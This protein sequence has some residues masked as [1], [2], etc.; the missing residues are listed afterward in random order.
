V[1]IYVEAGALDDAADAL[2]RLA[3]MN[4]RSPVVARLQQA[5]AARRPG[6]A[7]SPS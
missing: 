6:T 4:P 1:V 2:A 3:G 5:L 7:V